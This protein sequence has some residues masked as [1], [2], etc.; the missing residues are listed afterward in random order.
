MVKITKLTFF[1]CC[2][3]YLHPFLDPDPDP[4]PKPRVTDSDQAKVS[5]PDPHNCY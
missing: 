5:D 2:F 4:D 3:Y 1:D